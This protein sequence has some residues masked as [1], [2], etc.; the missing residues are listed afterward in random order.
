MPYIGK[1]C[2]FWHMKVC[3]LPRLKKEPWAVRIGQGSFV[4]DGRL[5]YHR[6]LSVGPSSHSSAGV[7]ILQRCN[8]ERGIER[9][10]T[11]PGQS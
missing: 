5:V 3:Q 9:P 8:H 11:G 4:L 6:P 2:Q 10:G 7:C 1:V